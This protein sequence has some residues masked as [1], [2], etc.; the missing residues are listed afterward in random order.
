[1]ERV[2]LVIEDDAG[3]RETLCHLLAEHGYQAIGAENGRQAL[4]RLQELAPPGLI[5][6]DLSMP[7]MNGWEFRKRQMNDPRLVVIPIVVISGE[8]ELRDK[9]QALGVEG[10]LAKPVDPEA[11]FDTVSLYCGEDHPPPS[12]SPAA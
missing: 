11:L 3:V 7:V 12:A 9:A 2:I 4:D 5:L 8:E 1:M 10:Y 6:L